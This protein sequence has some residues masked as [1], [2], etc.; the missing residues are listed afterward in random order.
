MKVALAKRLKAQRKARRLTIAEILG[1]DVGKSQ[2]GGL[3]SPEKRIRSGK[4]EFQHGSSP[5][6][7]RVKDIDSAIEVEEGSI[8]NIEF[9][10]ASA[11][12]T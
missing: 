1:T 10:G 11:R 5:T 4:D 9:D 8:R 2:I 6:P 12:V 7:I 3:P